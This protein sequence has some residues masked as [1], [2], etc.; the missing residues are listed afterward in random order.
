MIHIGQPYIESLGDKSRLCSKIT[1]NNTEYIMWYEVDKIYEKHLCYERADAFLI[2]L[3]PYAMT[4]DHNIS[5]TNA[6]S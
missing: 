4:N 6:V 3:L 2:C 1:C 5:C